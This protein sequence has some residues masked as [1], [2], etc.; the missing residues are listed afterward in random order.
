MTKKFSFRA[1]TNSE[2]SQLVK[3]LVDK[4]EEAGAESLKINKPVEELAQMQVRLQQALNQE[5]AYADSKVIRELDVLRGDV[6][7]GFQLIVE[8]YSRAGSSEKKEAARQ[9]RFM[10]RSRAKNVLRQNYQAKS[11][12]LDNVVQIIRTDPQNMAAVST[13][14]L[15]EWVTNLD[16]SNQNFEDRFK[17]RN[18]TM[19]LGSDI[20]AFG[21]LKKEVI[22]IIDRL[23]A[24]I[25]SR[26][27]TAKED[28]ADTAG[29]QRLV[30]EI[31]TLLESFMPYT[32][33]KGPKKEN[34]N[35]SG[36]QIPVSPA[37]V[38]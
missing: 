15:Q 5:R 25:A 33:P 9:L 30:G 13:L 23:F 28:G 14:G 6:F 38:P 17:V 22:P 4:A 34:P 19:S 2:F 12:I 26:F 3:L 36:P 18:T 8:G 31:N 10:L 11:A 37:S 24:L 32:L 21:K 7:L 27:N 29:Y 35:L 16:D 1:L 20:P